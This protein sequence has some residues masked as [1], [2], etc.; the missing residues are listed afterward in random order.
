MYDVTYL[1]EQV[2]M[3]SE[4]GRPYDLIVFGAT[5][6]TG[7]QVAIHLARRCDGKRWAI[8]GR[9]EGRLKANVLAH[10]DKLAQIEGWGA[11]Y[12]PPCIIVA[13][14]K[15]PEALRSMSAQCRIVLNCTGPYRFLG[16]PVVEACIE[17]GTDYC[18]LCGEPEFLDRMLLKHHDAAVEKG[19][20]VCCACA[21]DSV[22]ADLGVL[23]TA[24]QFTDGAVCSSV[25]SFLTFS[26]DEALGAAGHVTTFD[27]AVHG[28][29]AVGEL[30]AIRSQLKEKHP[31]SNLPVIGPKLQRQAGSFYEDRLG[32]YGLPFPGADASVVRNSQRILLEDADDRRLAPQYAAY[33]GYASRYW[34]CVTMLCGGL[35]GCL[36]GCGGVGRGCL[37][38]CPGC[39]TCGAF[40]AEGPSQAQM[41]GC[42]FEM[43]MIAKGYTSTEKATIGGEPDLEVRTQISGPE[44]G[45]VATPIIFLS[46]ADAVLEERAV[47]AKGGVFTPG[48][49]FH[50]T[51][52]VE[53]LD[54]VGVKFEVVA[55]RSLV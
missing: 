16:E 30:R 20:L 4:S 14:T 51:R 5:G 48:G 34:H 22:P 31:P 33:V 27:A 55:R 12:V 50:A 47:L 21:F 36:A 18:D 43:K 17:T 44:P 2:V 42:S 53:R 15:Q 49:L 1:C 39:F 54:A 11:M 25:E 32:C 29:G 13:D 19:V 38:A 40:T 28:F 35:F 46:V 45:Y 10:L 41:D 6:F 7:K 23:W 3:L 26:Y 8:A 24:K 37:L 9:D 52:L